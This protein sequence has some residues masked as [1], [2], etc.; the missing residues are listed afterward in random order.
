MLLMRSTR[1]A[2]VA[3]LVIALAA[4]RA[5]A[6][7]ARGA[8]AF[9]ESV[10]VNTH[11]I[12]DTAYRD[13]D[14]VRAALRELGVRHIRDGI[15]GTCPWQWNRYRALAADGVDLLAI[16]GS[17]ADDGPRRAGN[18]AALGALAGSVWGVEGANEWD[19]FSGRAPD[20][21]T[22]DR[23]Y[24]RWLWSA[25][26]ATP[27]LRW[28]PVVGPSLV[29][30]WETPSS[31][32]ILGDLTDALDYGNSHD[33]AG[34]QP[35]ELVSARGLALAR[36]VSGGRPVVVTEGGY[37]NAV[38]QANRDH[39]AVP[40]DV[41]A[42]Y[43]PRLL[44]ENFRLGFARTYVYELVNPVGGD[45][46]T[47]MQHSF[48]L[49]RADFSRKPAFVA[50]RNLLGALSDPGGPSAAAEVPVSVSAPEDVRRV[51]LRKADGRV[52]VVLW[53]AVSRWDRDAGAPLEVADVPV[54]VA[55]AAGAAAR[56]V[57]PVE[58]AASAA[59]DAPGGVAR[60]AVGGAPVIVEWTPPTAAGAQSRATRG[61]GVGESTPQ[62]AQPRAAI[63][64][65]SLQRAARRHLARQRAAKRRAVRQARAASRRARARG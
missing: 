24:Q 39:P 41:A 33:Y 35:P 13:F 57:R 17:P 55:F 63:R 49:L 21:A 44:L 65:A 16:A 61:G 59:V 22:Q 64:N 6:E 51:V 19:L 25:V 4:P 40:E 48:G 37:H 32:A 56:V 3:L 54:D 62:A 50:V 11:L 46:A 31:W 23:A 38:A 29:F 28:K 43:L 53:R 60:V 42:A 10:G 30:S 20:W 7:P 14:A 52:D 2:L 27:E 45:E 15:C 34:G 12:D 36:M 5:A 47:N 8:D 58:S 18:V 9:V 1:I 26:R